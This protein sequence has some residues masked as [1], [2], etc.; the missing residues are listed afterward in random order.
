MDLK[1]KKNCGERVVRLISNDKTRSYTLSMD[2]MYAFIFS[3]ELIC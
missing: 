3:N 2:D 1:K